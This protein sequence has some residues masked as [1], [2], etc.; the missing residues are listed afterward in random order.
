MC[1]CA[2]VCVV[3][4]VGLLHL[5]D[6]AA[7]TDEVGSF[8]RGRLKGGRLNDSSRGRCIRIQRP[9]TGGKKTTHTGS[10]NFQS[11]SLI[12]LSPTPL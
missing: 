8:S 6:L 10:F 9:W 12:V 7:C 5:R 4:V 1:V 2:C 3:V 11:R